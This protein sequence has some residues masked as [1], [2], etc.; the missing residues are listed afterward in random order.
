MGVGVKKCGAHHA[1]YKG[2]AGTHGPGREKQEFSRSLHGRTSRR[3]AAG[4]TAARDVSPASLLAYSVVRLRLLDGQAAFSGA[5]IGRMGR[6]DRDSMRG[7]GRAASGRS[8]LADPFYYLNNFKTVLTSLEERYR[9]LLSADELQFIAQFAELPRPSCALLVRM[10]MRKGAFFRLSRLRYPEIGNAAEAAAPLFGIGWLED[11]VLDVSQLHR[12]LTK[13]ELIG[14]LGLPRPLCKLNK[15]DLLDAL[16]PL[17]PG[18]RS[19]HAWCE[20]SHDRVFHPIVKPIAERFRLIFFGNFHQDWTEFVL[21]DLGIY[22]YETIPVQSAP[23]R[24]REHVKAFHQLYQCQRDLEDGAELA[25]VVAAIPPPIADSDWLEDVRQRLLFQ[26]AVAHE[27]IDAPA[28]LTLLSTCRY[29]GARMRTILLLERLGQWQAA[30]DLCLVARERPESEAERQQ[31]RRLLPRLNRKLGIAGENTRE[32]PTVDTFEVL[33]DPAT[34]LRSV[35]IVVRDY[36]AQ[37]EGP[38]STVHYVENGLINSLFGLLFWDAIFAPI[39]GAFFHDFQYGPADLGSGRFYERRR[40]QFAKGFAELESGEY[41]ATIRRRF[42]AKA[43]I[44]VPFVA[45]GL[46]TERLLEPALRCF[47]AAHLRL[48]FEWIVRDVVENRAGFPDLVQFW[49][50]ENRYRMV[51]VKGPGDRLQD[52]QRRFLEFCA[53]HRMPAFVCQVRGRE[54]AIPARMTST[55]ATSGETPEIDWTRNLGQ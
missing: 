21:A 5:R 33:L 30:R 22:N 4:D 44:Q 23:F 46:L 26:I 20:H 48:W 45:W 6:T 53:R 38:H 13:D 29:R 15:S 52:N 19:F 41:K 3:P 49:P 25:Q 32:L 37:Q 28:A 8:V 31:L 39:F 35:E 2:G 18:S 40:S 51:E 11:A 55:Q 36:L 17:Y 7:H 14:H 9:D 50:S 16:A 24:T 43:G 1:S 10:I 12:L 34:G 42:L 47:P 27:R 54:S